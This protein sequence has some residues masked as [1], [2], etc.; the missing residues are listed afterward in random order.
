MPGPHRSKRSALFRN[1]PYPRLCGLILLLLSL[2]GLLTAHHATLQRDLSL[3]LQSAVARLQA[4]S[5]AD[6]WQDG[7][8]ALLAQRA[9]GFRQLVLRGPQGKVLASAGNLTPRGWQW[10]PWTLRSGLS[11]MQHALLWH[12]G[13]VSGVADGGTLEYVVDP[14]AIALQSHDSAVTALYLLAGAGVLLSLLIFWGRR[15][16]DDAV[17]V[18]LQVER[19]AAPPPMPRSP[20]QRI[21]V[22]N[23]DEP[24]VSAL[25]HMLTQSGYGLMLVDGSLRVRWLSST[26]QA[27]TGWTAADASGQLVYT[28]CHLQDDAGEQVPTPAEQVLARNGTG[29]QRFAGWLIGRDGGRSAVDCAAVSFRRD[30]ELQALMLLQPAAGRRQVQQALQARA[31]AAEAVINELAESVLVTDDTGQ[32]RSA[33]ARALRMFG[34]GREEIL[35]QTIARLMPVPFMNAPEVKFTEYRTMPSRR[36]PRVVAWRKDATHFPA[37]L[38]VEPLPAGDDQ[39]D[40]VVIVRDVTERLRSVNLAQRLGRLLDSAVEEVYIFDAYSLYFLEVNRGARR[41]LGYGEDEMLTLT[42]L[43]ISA[44]LEP[45]VFQSY[46]ARLR[47]GEAEHLIYRT[48]HRRA[49]GSIYPVEVRL[50]FSRDEEPPVFMAIAADIAEREAEEQ[51]MSRL[52]HFDALTGLPNRPQLYQRMRVAITNARKGPRKLAL[53]FLDLDDFK[54]INDEYGHDVGDEVLKAVAERMRNALRTA[55]TVARLSGDEFVV[56]AEGIGNE[57]DAQLVAEKL[58]QAINAPLQCD[59]HSIQPNASIG[60]TL[61]PDDDSD[62]ETLLRHADEAMYA[63]K[64]MQRGGYRFYRLERSR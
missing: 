46:L 45:E 15:R 52:A 35:Q 20:V 26:A 30:P 6:G 11:R 51:E 48:R 58:L 12:R 37:E 31:R 28:V 60:I 53:M 25:L 13:E 33:N 8:D 50:N 27:M 36:L 7:L 64:R 16:P 34:Y 54:A 5:S 9:L 24:S 17:K 22:T 4:T 2:F 14:R 49:D 29:L 56:V 1:L 57:Q 41:N 63:S 43:M 40:Y 19:A 61:F 32:L 47:S 10:L 42:P 39:Q 44:D 23:P 38:V 21:A 59:S 3:S 18:R 62:V 55:D